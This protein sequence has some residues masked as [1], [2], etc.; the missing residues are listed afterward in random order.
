MSRVKIGVKSR[1]KRNIYEWINMFVKAWHG[2]GLT[3]K[4]NVLCK[5]GSEE[6]K[7]SIKEEAEWNGCGSSEKSFTFDNFF[8]YCCCWLFLIPF[9]L[10]FFQGRITLMSILCLLISSSICPSVHLGVCPSVLLSVYSQKNALLS[11]SSY[12]VITH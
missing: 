8:C 11:V 6:L 1:R 5:K 10:G 12:H 9:Y 3:R 2:K 7:T 4:R